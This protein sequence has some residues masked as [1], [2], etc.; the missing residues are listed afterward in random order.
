MFEMIGVGTAIVF[1]AY[2]L[3][4]TFFAVKSARSKKET[5]QNNKK[6]NKKHK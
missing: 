3:R 5:G 1:L 2:L 4:G 6:H